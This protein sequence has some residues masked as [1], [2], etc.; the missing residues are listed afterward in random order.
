MDQPD[1]AADAALVE[2]E[3][4]ALVLA[5]LELEFDELSLDDEPDEPDDS[6]PAVVVFAELEAP[7]ELFDDS[8][9]SLR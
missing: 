7:D 8:R 1:A 5:E 3:P 9:L 4:A 2:V 6:E